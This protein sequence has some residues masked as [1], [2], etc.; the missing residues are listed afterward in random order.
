MDAATIDL[1]ILTTF[2]GLELLG[3]LARGEEI[4]EKD[5]DLESWEVTA[6]RMRADLKA[7]GGSAT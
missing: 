6:A 1:L 7:T 2:K 5:L 4:T 3:K